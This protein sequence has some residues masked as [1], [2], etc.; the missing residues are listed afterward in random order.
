M[1]YNPK[2]IFKTQQHHSTDVDP[3]RQSY[4]DADYI[5]AQQYAEDCDVTVQLA[6]AL[7]EEAHLRAHCSRRWAECKIENS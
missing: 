1:I 5:R 6:R 7:A 3:M 2:K 4:L